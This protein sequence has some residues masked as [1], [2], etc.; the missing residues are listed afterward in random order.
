MGLSPLTHAALLI[1][2]D[3]E[4]FSSTVTTVGGGTITNAGTYGA[5][6]NGTLNAYNGGSVSAT[7]GQSGGTALQFNDVNGPGGTGNKGGLLIWQNPAITGDWSFM[8]SFK[9]SGAQAQYDRLFDTGR[10]SGDG[11]SGI[12]YD[13]T[14]VD[15]LSFG[16]GS[17]VI[18]I[19]RP[20]DEVWMHLALVYD[21]DGGS[22]VNGLISAYVDGVSYPFPLGAFVNTGSDDLSPSA[23]F[24]IGVG[25][26]VDNGFRPFT[27]AMDNLR[28]YD[29]PLSGAE[30]ASIYGAV[31]PEPSTFIMMGVA[32]A[33]LI[34]SQRFKQHRSC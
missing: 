11:A 2:M 10:G 15:V 3:F 1:D 6:G 24:S 16:V 20:A 23:G 4:G 12:L 27:G 28:I 25:S 8:L 33:G 7:T 32:F 29:E 18:N 34:V 14:S 21:E 30:V 5:A 13:G 9:S 17:R 19:D 31:I 26:D 22:G